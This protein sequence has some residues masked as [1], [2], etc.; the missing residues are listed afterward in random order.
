MNRFTDLA[1]IALLKYK[2]TNDANHLNEANRIIGMI[3]TELEAPDMSW[4]R[5]NE[6][7]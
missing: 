6:A 4:K 1:I 5:E 3:K 2:E 7:V